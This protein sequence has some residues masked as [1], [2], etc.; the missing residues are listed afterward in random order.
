MLPIE[1]KEFCGRGN[2]TD[3]AQLDILAR[4]L[5]GPFQKTMFDI[6]VFHPNASSYKKTN[7]KK[8]NLK[9]GFISHSNYMIKL[10]QPTMAGSLKNARA[11]INYLC[12]STVKYWNAVLTIQFILTCT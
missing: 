9:F 5:W 11:N 3:K 8:T 10:I 12:S 4:G 7:F 2:N 1:N 6:R